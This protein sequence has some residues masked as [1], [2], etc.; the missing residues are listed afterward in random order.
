[1]QALVNDLIMPI[2][3][4]VMPNVQWEAIQIVVFRVGH[5]IGALIKFLIIALVII[6]LV[7]LTTRIGLE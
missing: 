1:M 5:F 6:M 7:K 3:T 4:I 2:I